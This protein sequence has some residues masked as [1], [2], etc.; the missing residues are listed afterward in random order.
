MTGPNPIISKPFLTP[1]FTHTLQSSFPL[2][3]PFNGANGTQAG[4]LCYISPSRG[5]L[6]FV[7]LAAV[8]FRRHSTLRRVSVAK[9]MLHWFS[10]IE[11]VVLSASIGLRP[12]LIHAIERRF[13]VRPR[14]CIN[15]EALCLSFA[16]LFDLLCQSDALADQFPRGAPID[17]PAVR[18]Q[19][20]RSLT[21]ARRVRT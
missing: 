13:P 1:A 7:E 14:L 18:T 16:R 20:T 6:G 3:A 11:P 9:A 15:V 2:E 19:C 8:L 21:G 5:C 12:V 17:W 4:S 10:A